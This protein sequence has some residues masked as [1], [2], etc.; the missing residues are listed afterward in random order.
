MRGAL[1]IEDSYELTGEDLELLNDLI[2]QNLDTAK[3]TN[4]PFW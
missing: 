1:P 2:K 4:Q 3:K